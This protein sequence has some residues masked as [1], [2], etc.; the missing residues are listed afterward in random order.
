MKK[1]LLSFLLLGSLTASAQLADGSIAPDFTATDING[2]EHSLYADYLEQGKTVIIDISATWC[3]PCWNY[4]GTRALSDLYNVYGPGGS[5]EVVVLFI[6]GDPSTSVQSLYGTNTASDNS[7]TR[8][9][10]TNHSPYPIIDDTTGAISND[11]DIAY[12]PTVYMIC[13]TGVVTELTQ[14][15]VASLRSQINSNCQTLTGIT[16][17]ARFDATSATY[18]QTDGTLSTKLRNLG[19]NRLYS[20][21]AVLKENGNVL[22]TKTYSSTNGMAQFGTA[23]LNF[24]SVTFGSGEHTLEITE[25]NSATTLPHPEVATEEAAITINNAA[26]IQTELTVEIYTDFYPGEASWEI[27]SESGNTLVA[28]GGPYAEGDEDQYG[29]G[30]EDA[31]AIITSTVTLPDANDCYKVILKDAIGDGW[32]FASSTTYDANA[33]RGIKLY[34]GNELVYQ[35]NINLTTFSTATFGAALLTQTTADV[36]EIALEKGFSVFPN[37]TSGIL[38]VSCTEDVSIT[39]TDMTGKVVFSANNVHNGGSVNL[40][41]LQKGLYI[42]TLKGISGNEKSEKI[43]IN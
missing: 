31:N 29:G 35:K 37:P 16:D 20:A 1:T 19:T 23:T 30:G 39:V 7:V 26:P 17:I 18:C 42:A 5:N 41:A 12:F 10:W 36:E 21:T 43:V 22:A 38:N 34:N 33:F 13:P 27:R 11:Y 40:S 3:G 14:P 4:H 32:Y 25:L 6:E 28:S 2:V 8:G 9:N 15:S 24:P